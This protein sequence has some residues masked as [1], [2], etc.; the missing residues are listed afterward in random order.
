LLRGWESRRGAPSRTAV[1]EGVEINMIIV[2][3]LYGYFKQLVTGF[4]QG[5]DTI[6]ES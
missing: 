2:D 4:I 6:D 3:E 1:G 5:K